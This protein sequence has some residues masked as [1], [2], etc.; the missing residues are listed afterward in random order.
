MANYIFMAVYGGVLAAVTGTTILNK[1]IETIAMLV[2]ALIALN[3]HKL[4][5]NKI[6]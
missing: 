4:F 3:L 5:S 6:Q 2:M 1:P